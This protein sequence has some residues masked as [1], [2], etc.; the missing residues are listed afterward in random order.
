[1]GRNIGKNV[2]KSLI[3]KGNQKLIDH[4]KQTATGALKTAS[5]IAIYK[6]VEPT[7]NL[8]SRQ[9]CWQNYKS[10]KNFTKE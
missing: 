2:S 9:N 1:M 4:A 3:S 5:K 8:I 7:G 6:T 10:F